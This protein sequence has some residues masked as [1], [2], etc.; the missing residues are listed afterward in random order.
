MNYHAH[1]YFK[2]DWLPQARELDGR[3]RK[4]LARRPDG[5]AYRIHLF[6]RVVGPHVLPMLE[7]DFPGSEY[8]S[9]VEWLDEN[10]EGRSVLIHEDTGDDPRDH[11]EGARWLGEPLPIRFEFFEEI[12][13]D[14]RKVIHRK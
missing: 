12:K 9:I 14:P 11:G 13:A 8:D 7:I 10:R 6:D 4:W 1:L 3:L 5:N 2:P